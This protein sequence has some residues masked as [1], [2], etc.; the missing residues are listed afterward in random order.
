MVKCN[1]HLFHPVDTG[2]KL[3]VHKNLKCIFNDPNIALVSCDKKLCVIIMSRRD[4][5]KKL[6]E[7]LT[8][9]M[10]HGVHI[11][12]EKR[13]L[14]KVDYNIKLAQKINFNC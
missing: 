3:N 4:H 9:G 7:S 2:R 10:Q 14:K 13:T 5:F 1:H 11:V 8:V 12:T 6:Q